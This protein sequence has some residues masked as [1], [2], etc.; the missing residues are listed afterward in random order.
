M[1]TESVFLVTRG[2]FLCRKNT[3]GSKSSTCHL[4]DSRDLETDISV[5]YLHMAKGLQKTKRHD[6]VTYTLFFGDAR[7]S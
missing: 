2:R 7:H 6:L 1:D 4:Y 5:K 3:Y